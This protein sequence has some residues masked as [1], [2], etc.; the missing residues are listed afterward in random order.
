MENRL[1]KNS[2]T[3]KLPEGR[4]WLYVQTL[5][6]KIWYVQTI[7]TEGTTISLPYTGLNVSA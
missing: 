3:R 2:N 1:L 4:F 5:G 6:T 7:K